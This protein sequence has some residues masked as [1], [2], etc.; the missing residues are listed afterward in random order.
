MNQPHR[1][2]RIRDKSLTEPSLELLQLPWQFVAAGIVA[3]LVLI[4]SARLL[5]NR[6]LRPPVGLVVTR[7]AAPVA[8]G[9]ATTPNS[10]LSRPA[11]NAPSYRSQVHARTPSAHWRH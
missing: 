11:A 1:A 6:Y 4:V 2:E 5:A 9:E 3:F 10:V 7:T 8:V